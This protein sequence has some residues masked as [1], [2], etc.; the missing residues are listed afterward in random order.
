MD[1]WTVIDGCDCL[2]QAWQFASEW[3]PLVL[4]QLD[5]S[6]EARSSLDDVRLSKTISKAIPREFFIGLKADCYCNSVPSH[7]CLSEGQIP[8]AYDGVKQ[9]ILHD[10]KYV[11]ESRMKFIDSAI[12]GLTERKFIWSTGFIALHQPLFSW[13]AL[14]GAWRHMSLQIVSSWNWTAHDAHTQI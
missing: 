12:E 13:V 8:L 5:G 11:A 3:L 1:S 14:R 7:H 2:C 9:E 4:L 6:A 10:W